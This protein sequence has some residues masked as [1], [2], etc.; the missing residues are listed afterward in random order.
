MGGWGLNTREISELH[1][2]RSVINNKSWE[3]MEGFYSC[4][5]V[6]CCMLISFL[7]HFHP[8]SCVVNFVHLTTVLSNSVDV[9][10]TA[11]L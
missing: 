10:F 8:D 2:I 1:L 3:F 11:V 6:C 5:F 7:H 4:L 9:M